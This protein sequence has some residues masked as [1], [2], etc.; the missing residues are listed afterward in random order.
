VICKGALEKYSQQYHLETWP[1]EEWFF[2][3]AS[4]MIC[5]HLAIEVLGAKSEIIDSKVVGETG[6][7]PVTPG[8]EVARQPISADDCG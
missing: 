8:L 6:I 2:L 5:G 1:A 7:E 4:K 3:K